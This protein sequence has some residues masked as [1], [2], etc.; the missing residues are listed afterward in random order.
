MKKYNVIP[1]L[2]LLYLMF[3]CYLGYP[4]YASGEYSSLRY[5]GVTAITLVF[6]IAIRVLMKRRADRERTDR[7]D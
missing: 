7:H 6:I 3:M 4:R 5:F 1:L 2:L